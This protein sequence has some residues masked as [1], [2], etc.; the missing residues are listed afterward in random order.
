[1]RLLDDST[2]ETTS[3]Y[4]VDANEACWSV[5]SG[6]LGFIPAT[7][8]RSLSSV[9]SS[10][11]AENVS[12]CSGK[13]DC[14]RLL[15]DST[16]E[17]T[18][19]Y[20]VDANKAC[21][22]VSSGQLGDDPATLRLSLN[23][24]PSSIVTK[25]LSACAGKRDCV[26]LLDDATFETTSRYEVD[27]NEAC[28]S[29]SSGQLGDDPATYYCVGTAYE[30]DEAEPKKVCPG[31]RVCFCCPCKCVPSMVQA[32]ISMH[33]VHTAGLSAA[34]SLGT[35]LRR[36][37]AWALH[38]KMMRRSPRRYAMMLGTGNLVDTNISAI[39]PVQCTACAPCTVVMSQQ[40]QAGS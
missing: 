7:L 13:R 23:K 18:S 32:S 15:D 11:V 31:F 37:T 34:A 9:F 1:M 28:W 16:F 22:S 40:Q 38:M 19:R 17:T 8:R 2:C 10:A 36:T 25:Y 30:D 14:V 21:W 12:V 24:D 39:R 35:I 5:S 6:Q 29:V 27:A 33:T 3:R 26:R 20:E 4:E